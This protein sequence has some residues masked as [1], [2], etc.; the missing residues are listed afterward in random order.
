MFCMKCGKQ[1]ADDA[2][3]C[4]AC[5]SSQTD[6]EQPPQTSGA[7]RNSNAKTIV[8]IIAIFLIFSIKNVLMFV[9]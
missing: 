8:I 7:V 1:L 6:I 2:V 4:P 9:H 3:F 5:G